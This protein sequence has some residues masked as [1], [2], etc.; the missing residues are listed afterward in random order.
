M[1]S[2]K[3]YSSLPFTLSKLLDDNPSYERDYDKSSLQILKQDIMSNL[4]MLFHSKSHILDERFKDTV[5]CYG[6]KDFSGENLSKISIEKFKDEIIY[7]ISSFEPRIDK[8]SLDI[9]LLDNG[10]KYLY[11]LRISALININDVRE[12]FIFN[13]N[14][15]FERSSC[16]IDF[17]GEKFE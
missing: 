11:E 16:S 3:H 9:S 1:H 13:L 4:K 8:N 17:L 14:F 15:D 10:L 7:Q 6:M 5:L 12:E 2:K